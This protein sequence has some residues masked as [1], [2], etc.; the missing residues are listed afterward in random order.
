VAQQQGVVLNDRQVAGRLALQWVQ[1][2]WSDCAFRQ[3]YSHHCAFFTKQY[4]LEAVKKNGTS[5]GRYGR[6][7][8]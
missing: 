4:K 5:N 1:L 8:V 3:V 2:L 6:V 7:V